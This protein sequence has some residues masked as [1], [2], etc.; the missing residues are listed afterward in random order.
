MIPLGGAPA[1][2]FCFFKVRLKD[3]RNRLAVVLFFNF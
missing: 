1:T 2:V 3:G